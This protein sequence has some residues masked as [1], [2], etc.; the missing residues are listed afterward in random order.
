MR[1]RGLTKRKPVA[2]VG[3]I[4]PALIA[5]IV[6]LGSTL[7]AS[8]A[9]AQSAP[10]GTVTRGVPDPGSR[11]GLGRAP[12]ATTIDAT[13]AFAST[14]TPAFGSTPTPAFSGTPTPALSPAQTS[15]VGSTASISVDGTVSGG[16]TG[17]ISTDGDTAADISANGTS[18]M[19]ATGNDAGTT[20]SALPTGR[21][22][23][24]TAV[25]SPSGRFG[26]INPAVQGGAA[27]GS[28][29]HPAANDTSPGFI[30]VT[31]TAPLNVPATRPMQFTM[32]CPDSRPQ[33]ECKVPPTFVVAE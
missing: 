2:L 27:V 26:Q 22:A 33:S 16:V 19:A 8:G 1:Y 12:E 14:P 11:D 5:A 18:S 9:L 23:S 28:G 21:S 13:P 20:E 25:N 17:T 6:L 32:I 3:Q 29:N 15:P 24:A 10:S 30:I 7:V 31:G 4:S